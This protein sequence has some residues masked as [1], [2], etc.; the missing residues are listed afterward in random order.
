MEHLDECEKTMLAEFYDFVK[1]HQHGHNW[2]HWNMRDSNFGF[3]ALAHRFLVLGGDPVPIDDAYKV[4]LSPLLVS[5]YGPNYTDHGRIEW[6]VKANGIRS[7]A[8]LTG[9]QEAE[10]FEKGNFVAMHQSTLVKVEAF[11]QF[12][13]MA[14]GRTLKTKSN[15][16]RDVYLTSVASFGQAIAAHWLF[17]VGLGAIGVIGFV[18]SAVGAWPVIT[19]WFRK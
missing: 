13:V 7:E 5:V 16:V 1:A 15:I 11:N 18:L 2:I 19:A 17:A 3:E 12:A 14:A 9:A 6:L 4:D 8:F 10:A